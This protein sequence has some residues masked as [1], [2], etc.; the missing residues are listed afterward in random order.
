[1]FLKQA[2]RVV[3]A[4]ATVVMLSGAASAATVGAGTFN[5]SGSIR[6][7]EY[8][9][10]FGYY[11]VPTATSADQTASVVLPTS[12]AFGDL[13]AG[14][15]AGIKNILTPVNGG[16]FGPGPV[17][18][19][20]P[21]TLPQFLT[22]SDG[23]DV[24]LTGLAVAGG[25]PVCSSTSNPGTTGYTCQAQPGSPIILENGPQGVTALMNLSGN[26][27]Y[28]S[29][30]STT[31]PIV[32]KFSASFADTTIAGLLTQFNS[33]GYIATGYQ[34]AFTTAPTTTPEPASMALLGAGLF[35]LG[36]LGKKKL[37]K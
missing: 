14:D 31:T 19:G 3:G 28:A 1:M 17:V 32:G 36:L 23:I 13:A 2:S 8:A 6:I 16:H 18:P 4:L 35:G 11:A 10:L 21:F 27:Y 25:V 26:A 33:Q 5:I 7:Q 37:A 15:T 20:S 34:A 9:F 29:S 12:G 30:M 24:D 22:L